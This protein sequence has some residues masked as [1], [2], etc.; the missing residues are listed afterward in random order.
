MIQEDDGDGGAIVATP[1]LDASRVEPADDRPQVGSW[2]WVS[3]ED[4]RE[5]ESEYDRPGKLWL[6]CVIAV[7]SN[8]AEVKGVH[9]ST[10]IAL[11]DFHARCSAEPD[12]QNFISA[13][14]GLRRESVRELMGQIRELCHRLGVPMR[15]ALAEVETSSQ[16]LATAHSIGDVKRHKTALVE[17]KEKTL[18]ELFK[19]IKKQHEQMAT[20]MKAELI[21]AEAELEAARE[22][23]GVIEGKIH[24]VELYAG[25]TE[26]L[27]CVREGEPA[28]I[29]ERVRLMQRM[30]YMDEECLVRYEAGGMD[31]Q[32]VEAFDAWLTREEN[33]GR[34]FTG[35]R[36]I[37]AFRVRRFDKEYKGLDAFIRFHMNEANKQTFLYIRNGGQLWRMQTSID[38]GE[39]LFPDRE[40][41]DLLGDDELWVKDSEF[42]IE[43]GT[44]IITGRR[45]A[46]MVQDH[47]ERRRV[48]AHKLWQWHR[49]GKPDGS[50][51][52][53]IVAG[54]DEHWSGGRR[55]GPGDEILLTGKP[56]G[57]WHHDGLDRPSYLQYE[58][59]TP[60]HIY[61]DDAMRRVQK[62]TLEHNRIAVIVQGLLDRSTCLHPHPPWRIWTPEGFASGVELSY[63]VSRALTNGEAPDFEAYRR[64]L[65]RGIR[66]G[67]HTLGQK[68]AWLAHMS[69]MY[70]DKWWRYTRYGD[71]PDDIHRV[72]RV[73]RDGSCEFR[74]TR[75]RVTAKWAPDPENPGYRRAIYPD[76]PCGWTCPADVLTCV[77]AYT[78][79][80][81]HLFFDDPRTRADY[82]RWAPILLA[83]EDWHA[84]RRAQEQ[85]Q[86]QAPPNATRKKRRK[87]I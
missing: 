6:A 72:E 49:A 52:Y 37:V 78:P 45:R 55:V 13:Q 35:R 27:A 66:P 62:A 38:F 7:G 3:S 65:N 51:K 71:G 43:H 32:D 70:G 9:W 48:A 22:V 58:L 46:A 83:C 64:Q 23:T 68:H 36:C 85:E 73:R 80:D 84:A 77:D 82:L 67:C 69:E 28:G 25:L 60:S 16:A 75:R 57:T 30:H 33:F 87:R 1:E 21:P 61:H 42:E 19:Q 59:L 56:Y 20:W 4:S 18:P 26:E 79:G 5:D 76:L 47:R 86:E 29:D 15:Q 2:W 54:E 14:V 24:T 31:F 44:G 81:L 17:A 34:I 74:W 8:Y 50:W 53:T 10:R 39:E 40:S 41:S 63:D 11:D 12:P